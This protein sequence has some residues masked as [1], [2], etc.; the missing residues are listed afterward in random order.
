M[1]TNQHTQRRVRILVADDDQDDCLLT[2]E[3]FE[4]SQI[5]TRLDFVHDG[6]QL[7]N[8]LLHRPPFEDAKKYPLPGLILMDLNMPRVDGREA[9]TAIK[10]HPHLRCIPVIVLTTSCSE[11]DILYSYQCGASSYITK[12]VSYSGLVDMAKHLGSYW[13]DLVQLPNLNQL[14]EV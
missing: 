6:E 12:S 3:A 11:Q 8:Y 14:S 10:Q 9:L 4:E 13:L 2:R 1:N 5:A 7:M